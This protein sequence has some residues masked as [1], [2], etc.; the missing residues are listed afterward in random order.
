MLPSAGDQVG[1]YQL[2]RPL[3]E[4]AAAVVW[5]ATA[6]GPGGFKKQV[7]L[8]LLKATDNDRMVAD[9]LREARLTA[10]L[11]HPNT[12]SV[13]TVDQHEDQFFV[14]MEL[15]EGGTLRE[16]ISRV[17][18]L[19]LGFPLSVILDLGIDVARGLDHAHTATDPDGHPLCVLHRDLKPESI[20][21]DSTG[22]A[23][24]TDFGL[25]KVLG[26]ATRTGIGDIKGTS[27]YV[28]P[29]VW[30]GSRDFHPR[31]D[32]FALGCI[33]YELLT[34][35]RLFDGPMQTVFE[36]I[37][38][39]DSATEAAAVRDVAPVLEPVVERLIR[40]DPT[41]RYQS[42][43]EVLE[44]LESLRSAAAAG[45]GVCTFRSL[46]EVVS[47][48]GGQTNEPV[49]DALLVSGDPRWV[50]IANRA[51]GRRPPDPEPTARSRPLARTPTLVLLAGTLLMV[52]ALLLLAA[53]R[54]F[55]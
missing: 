19:Q 52:L 48:P 12:V 13:L 55:A 29:E 15:V 47:T 24:L 36:Q 53:A 4:G 39:R 21:L 6:T 37:T 49:I 43:M 8:K 42:A 5:L 10:L 27:R 44:D 26:E 31:G 34:L 11:A 18:R 41:S 17:K 28:P 33:L 20:L 16:L 30:K 40:R 22:R 1:P 38:K 50:A 7:A 51:S 46:V 45:P 14:A 2:E 3:G 35:R 9:L 23:R 54:I 25:A 32:L